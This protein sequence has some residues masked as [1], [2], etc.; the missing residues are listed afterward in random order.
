VAERTR[1]A[2]VQVIGEFFANVYE[3]TVS[4]YAVLVMQYSPSNIRIEVRDFDGPKV[5]GSYPA[6]AVAEDGDESLRG[7]V[8]V[9]SFAVSW[10]SAPNGDRGLVRFAEIALWT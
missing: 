6:L 10:G 1:D 9:N 5:E 8:L 4:E 2:V 7:L 3:H